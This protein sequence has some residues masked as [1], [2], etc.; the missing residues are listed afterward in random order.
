MTVFLGTRSRTARNSRHTHYQLSTVRR[1]LGVRFRAAASQETANAG[2]S[3]AGE[4]YSEGE[5]AASNGAGDSPLSTPAAHSANSEEGGDDSAMAGGDTGRGADGGTDAPTA[6]PAQMLTPPRAAQSNTKA[7]TNVTETV[8]MAAVTPPPSAV[9]VRAPAASPAATPSATGATATT[10]AALPTHSATPAC[11]DA[12]AGGSTLQDGGPAAGKKKGVTASVEAGECDE[13]GVA[14][15]AD[16]SALA[17][18]PEPPRMGVKALD[19]TGAVPVGQSEPSGSGTTAGAPRTTPEHSQPHSSSNQRTPDNCPMPG[20][21]QVGSTSS[22]FVQ[23][24][25]ARHPTSAPMAP[26]ANPPFPADPSQAPPSASPMPGL[27][28]A[29]DPGGADAE[30]MAETNA[31]DVAQREDNAAAGESRER[32]RGMGV[33]RAGEDAA[34]QVPTP[35]QPTTALETTGK[36]K[37]ERAE[38]QE[39]GAAH[40]APAAEQPEVAA[41]NAREVPT[42]SRVAMNMKLGEAF[43]VTSSYIKDFMLACEGTEG[44][45][46]RGAAPTAHPPPAKRQDQNQPVNRSDGTTP[47]TQL[48]N[49]NASQIQAR[50]EGTAANTPLAQPETQQHPENINTDAPARTD[51]EQTLTLYCPVEFDPWGGE[52]EAEQP[53]S[54]RSHQDPDADLVNLTRRDIKKAAAAIMR[55]EELGL[56]GLGAAYRLA[57]GDDLPTVWSRLFDDLQPLLLDKTPPEPPAGLPPATLRE[58]VGKALEE[59]LASFQDSLRSFSRVSNGLKELQKQ[60][61]EGEVTHALRISTPTLQLTDAVLQEQL[62]RELE[63]QMKSFKTK[64]HVTLLVYK[65]REKAVGEATLELWQKRAHAGFEPFLEGN[66]HLLNGHTT[67]GTPAADTYLKKLAAD[68]LARGMAR[69]LMCHARGQRLSHLQQH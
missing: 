39:I 67:P 9:P 37:A 25:A 58:T 62:N 1:R 32:E 20:M 10:A 55:G 19:A 31:A 21:Q 12:A 15:V 51:R 45:P 23:D 47:A 50:D 69:E 53:M 24:G 46:S 59:E 2:T 54:P 63:D 34:V 65:E 35:S 61:R 11:P 8:T 7:N 26:L 42:G 16:S 13:G 5:R 60:L 48:P 43:V 41:A 29:R 36:D 38:A 64:A 33:G 57:E 66:P 17:A 22:L 18:T 3:G 30:V 14:G 40:P 52:D 68:Y 27:L 56:R 49:S 28:T 6:T 44:Q 4:E